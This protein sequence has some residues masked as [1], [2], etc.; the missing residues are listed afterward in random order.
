MNTAP[1]TA[2]Q[3]VLNQRDERKFVDKQKEKGVNGGKAARRAANRHERKRG[4]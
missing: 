3:N 1:N 2:V 4:R